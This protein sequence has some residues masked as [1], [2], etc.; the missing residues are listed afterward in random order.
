MMQIFRC[1][2]GCWI[3]N[4]Y[5]WCMSITWMKLHIVVLNKVVVVVCFCLPLLIPFWFYFLFHSV[6]FPFCPS[7]SISGLCDLCDFSLILMICC[8]LPHHPIPL[9][10]PHCLL[11]F[12]LV[13]FLGLRASCY[14]PSIP[15]LYPLFSWW[16]HTFIGMNC[17]L[18]YY[19][20]AF[21][22]YFLHMS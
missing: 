15:I 17:S 11:F 4:K 14:S 21:A 6:F 18:C 13:C 5:K 16:I 3:Y 20:H 10:C 2:Y 19:S 1:W 8:P 22:F 9:S 12:F 7:Y